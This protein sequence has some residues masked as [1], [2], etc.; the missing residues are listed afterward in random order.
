MGRGSGNADCV[1]LGPLSTCD[2][3]GFVRA[4]EFR[5]EAETASLA[6]SGSN[7]GFASGLGIARGPDPFASSDVVAGS[8][9][10]GAFSSS[11]VFASSGD[12]YYYD[13]DDD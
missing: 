10:D 3:D 1:S 12:N 9:P 6:R 2:T 8:A 5:A 11:S 7:S 4:R 13:G